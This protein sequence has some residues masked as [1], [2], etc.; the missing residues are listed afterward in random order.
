[1]AAVVGPPN[2]PI[3]EPGENCWRVA[4]A[5]KATLV[6][7]AQ[8]YFRLAAEMMRMARRRIIIIGWDFDTRIRL[9][10]EGPKHATPTLGEFI[11]TLARERPELEIRILRWD[12]GAFRSWK[13]GSM[14]LDLARWRMQS[15]IHMRFDGAHPTGCSHHQKI[16]IVDD[17]LAVCGGIDMTDNRWD[18]RDHLPRDPR[19]TRPGGRPYPP[20]HD[21]TMIS[22]GE[23]AEAISELARTRWFVATGERLPSVA[24]HGVL[25]PEGLVA[26]FENVCFAIARTIAPWHDNPAV[27]EVEALHLATIARATR[28]IYA[29]NQYFTSPR[30]AAALVERMKEV[31]ALEVVLVTP[32][33]ADGWLEKKAMDG[34]R[35]RLVNAILREVGP[36][37]LR[38]LY[39]VNAGGEA[40]YVHAKITIVDDRVLRIGSANLNNRS[41][42]LDSECDLMLE[43]GGDPALTAC[44]TTIRDRL[45]AEHTG[46]TQAEVEAAMAAH[47]G[48]LIRAIG[49]LTREGRALVALPL[50]PPTGVRAVIAD[51]ELLDAESSDQMFELFSRRRRLIRRFR[52]VRGKV[53]RRFDRSRQRSGRKSGT[54]R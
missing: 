5:D 26:D 4:H 3:A 9:E 46:A 30:I 8:D 17:D 22:T 24:E 51:N 53:R 25:W 36:D 28:T 41:M 38:V 29:E 32:L 43:T 20:W 13:R 11:L 2:D 16:L 52:A 1:M 12:F 7:D 19:R 54:D 40:I 49:S 47:D 31:P 23:V 50:D 48:S 37:R 6:V 33:T 10:Q 21:A 35:V 39:P 14:M 44:V 45:V 18:T 34:A 15:N 42:A 27:R